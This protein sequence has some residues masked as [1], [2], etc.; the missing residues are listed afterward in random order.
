MLDLFIAVTAAIAAGAVVGLVTS[1]LTVRDR[2]K[3]RGFGG[4]P[5]HRPRFLD[6]VRDVID[7]S[8]GV[9]LIRKLTRRPTA[10]PEEPTIPPTPLTADEVA[11]RIGVTGA[12]PPAR[13]DPSVPPRPLVTGG[14][15]NT[16]TP[17]PELD[18]LTP[19]RPIAATPPV[20]VGRRERLV[21]DSAVALLGLVAI[22]VAAVV[23]SP[24]SPSGEPDGS[25]FVVNRA[26]D[27]QAPS[28]TIDATSAEPTGE[29]AVETDTPASMPESTPR[30]TPK[31]PAPVKPPTAHPIPRATPRSTPTSRSTPK[32]TSMPTAAP[33][34]APTP[35][36]TAV[37]TPEPTPAPTPDP[38]ATPTPLPTPP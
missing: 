33:T 25:V 17:G 21:R 1:V 28:D 32:P 16:V 27:S 26:I 22:G 14:V 34:P 38:T 9:F 7:R 36:P 4:Q 2:P 20:A 15:A 19:G 11:Y 29:V 10:P 5:L 8:I 6:S 12:Q 31:P 18:R 37:P 24:H 13:P 3:V 30:D 35:T 23:V